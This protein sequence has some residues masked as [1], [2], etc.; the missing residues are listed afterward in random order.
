MKKIIFALICFGLIWSQELFAGQQ[1]QVI[2]HA[3][4]RKE[5]RGTSAAIRNVDHGRFDLISQQKV[6]N[7]YKIQVDN[8]EGWIYS[9]SVRIVSSGPMTIKLSSFNTLHLGWGQTKSLESL[10]VIIGQ[11]DI[12]ALSEVMK[13]PHLEELEGE[14]ES[15]T[16]ADWQWTQSEL[17]G[18]S[19]YKE[20]Y[21]YIWRTDRVTL[22]S[23][24]AYVFPDED[25]HFIREPYIASFRSGNF[26]F[27]VIAIH[28]IYG[29]KEERE[30]EARQLDNLFK[31]VQNQDP[32]ENDVILV[33]DFNLPPMEEAWDE[34][35]DIANMICLLHPPTRTSLGEEGLSQLY[36]N[37]WFETHHVSEYTDQVEVFDFVLEMFDGDYAEGK[38]VVSDHLPI[39]VEF[40][41]DMEDDDPS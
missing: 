7:W 1:V 30:A 25:D 31:T 34:M 11:Y 19:T 16:G 22:I 4:I 32:G 14:L 9:R 21:A 17:I 40:R 27:T 33:G 41:T 36:D 28:L 3:V 12:I 23:G 20:R 39:W 5:P 10:A 8:Q 35:K 29:E 2:R 26:D 6:N 24:S 15:L 13:N 18:R 37:I 38:K